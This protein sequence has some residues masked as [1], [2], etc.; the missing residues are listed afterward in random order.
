MN[1]YG[2]MKHWKKFLK[3]CAFRHVVQRVK[4][5][6]MHGME[7]KEAGQNV[8]ICPIIFFNLHNIVSFICLH[9]KILVLTSD[10]LALVVTFLCERK[11]KRQSEARL[12]KKQIKNSES[13]KT[14]MSKTHALFS[15][16]II[17]KQRSWSAGVK[18]GLF[19]LFLHGLHLIHLI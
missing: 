13:E 2:P 6:T 17:L 4:T 5:C 16:L 1:Q 14:C 8:W 10:L 18:F 9:L 12:K 7:S 19:S 15:F 3:D 11:N